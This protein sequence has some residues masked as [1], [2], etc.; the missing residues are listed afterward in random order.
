MPFAEAVD[1]S[2]PYTSKSMA[3]IEVSG[4]AMHL[5]MGLALG[6][7]TYEGLVQ[8]E[9][10]LHAVAQRFSDS[11]DVLAVSD[12]ARIRQLLDALGLAYSN[13][14]PPDEYIDIV[15]QANTR[16]IRELVA[17][18]TADK[19]AD[20]AD[21][22]VRERIQRYNQ[23]VVRITKKPVTTTD[24]TIFT[25]LAAHAFG[26]SWLTS[27]GVALT[28]RVA[29]RIGDLVDATKAGD[30]LD[31]LRGKLNRVPKES[32]RL[33]RIRSRLDQARRQS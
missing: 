28:S 31:W 19:H 30:A 17:S 7:A 9:V 25:G 1:Q 2:V 29:G 15:D 6:A 11:A 12:G 10:L 5:S 26:A 23:G 20:D 18:L 4:A 27:L 16:R 3:P 14:I 33:Y 8:N 24:I 22:D 13:D 21:Q 32:I